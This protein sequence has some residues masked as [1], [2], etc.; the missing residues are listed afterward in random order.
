MPATTVVGCSLAVVEAG[1]SFTT[2]ESDDSHGG[3]CG[4]PWAMIIKDLE[5]AGPQSRGQVVSHVGRAEGRPRQVAGD[6]PELETAGPPGQG[7]VV[8]PGQ[9]AEGLTGQGN[10]NSLLNLRISSQAWCRLQI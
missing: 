8:P 9:G 3:P 10:W 4:D 7:M 1:D 5:V 6:P 2:A